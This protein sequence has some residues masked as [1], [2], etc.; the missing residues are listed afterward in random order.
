MIRLQHHETGKNSAMS[1]TKQK[2]WI[3]VKD[4]LFSV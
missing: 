3:D 2:D 1:K 4:K